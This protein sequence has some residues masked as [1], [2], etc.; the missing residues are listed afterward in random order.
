MDEELVR[1]HLSLT[2]IPNIGDSHIQLLLQHYPSPLDIFSSNR[3]MLESISGI[4][5]VRA[6]E[7]L[8][9]NQHHLVEQELHFIRKNKIQVLIKGFPEYPQRLLHCADAPHVLYYKGNTDLQSKR[10]VAIIGTR[11]PTEY[12]KEIVAELIHTLMEYDAVVLSGLA[13]GIDSLTHRASVNAK[14][15]TVGVL[16]H[17]LDKIYPFV[18]RELAVEMVKHGGLLTEFMS[19]TQPDRQNFPKRNRIVAGLADVVVV[20]ESG[21]K[22]GSLITADIAN[23]YHKD[24][25]AFPGRCKDVQSEGCN[26]LIKSNRANLICS[27]DDL[28]RF[29]NWDDHARSKNTYQVKLFEQLSEEERQVVDLIQN[30]PMLTIDAFSGRTTVRPSNLAGILLGLEIKGIIRVLPGNRYQV[31]AS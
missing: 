25:L 6:Q 9:F 21:I 5:Q 30:N 22:G 12:G 31:S 17:G 1:A 29:M 11:S 3:K 15:P 28:I 16:G 26:W 8:Q 24:V 20:V 18:N 10:M 19:G 7:I 14:I 13:Y 27:G 23:S 2:L 4:G